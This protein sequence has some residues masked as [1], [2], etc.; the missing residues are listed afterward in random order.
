MCTV[1]FIACRRGYLLA[2]NR[3]EKL[4]RAAGL[5]P[6][7]L[8]VGGRVVLSPSEAGGGTW[9]AVNDAGVT[10]ALV[11]WYGIK[12]AVGPQAVSRGSV[13]RAVAA[14]NSAAGAM[15]ILGRLPLARTN[16][17]RLVGIFARPGVIYEWCW[18]L[19]TLVCRRRPWKSQQWISSGY[20]ELAAQK[21]RSAAFRRALKLRPAGGLGWLRR[22]HGSHDPNAGPLSICMHRADAATVSYT[23]VAAS[24]RRVAM[25]YRNRALCGRAAGSRW[26]GL[27]RLFL[28][29]RRERAAPGS[30]KGNR[31]G[32]PWAR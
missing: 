25:A 19:R 20:D 24:D 16:P 18:D 23:E 5:P 9:I 1:S 29:V 13:V 10:F 27:R 17:F 11:N 12:A 4:S 26:R 6:K 7:K 15:R 3:D 30:R 22:L 21:A 31:P 28:P 32:W 2:M 8:T 14:E